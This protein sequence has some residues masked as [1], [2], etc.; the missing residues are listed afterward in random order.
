MIYGIKGANLM[1]KPAISI[2]AEINEFQLELDLYDKI[3]FISGDSGIGK[4]YLYEQLSLLSTEKEFSYIK[5]FNYLSP[6][7]ETQVKSVAEN[8]D[9][10]IVI[11][12]FETLWSKNLTAIVMMSPAK[13]MLISRD[14][15][16]LMQRKHGVAE[17]NIEG[18]FISLAYPLVRRAE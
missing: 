18:N 8:A 13:F 16:G 12:N 14:Y 10:L 15:F 3:V 5:C 4:S 11:D 7:L 9:N 17:L 2:Q 1:I 6:D